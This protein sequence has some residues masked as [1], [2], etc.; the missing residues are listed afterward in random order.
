MNRLFFLVGQSNTGKDTIIN[1]LG[2][3]RFVYSTTRP[4]RAG[5]IDGRTYHFRT[6]EEFKSSLENGDIIEYRLY[7]TDFGD[8]YYYTEKTEIIEDCIISGTPDMCKSLINYYGD[9][10]VPIFVQVPDRERL[11][12]G[13][14]REDLNTQN[15]KEVARRFYSEFSEYTDENLSSIPNLKVVLNNDIE[16]CVFDIKNLISNYT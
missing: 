1:K 8:V 4:M 9:I 13:I 3:K 2:M 15:Y 6:D 10:V 14:L 5:E 12:R 16:T 7:H 11:M